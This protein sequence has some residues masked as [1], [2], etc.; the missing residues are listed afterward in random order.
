MVKWISIFLLVVVMGNTSFAQKNAL[1][2]EGASPDLYLLHKVVPKEN[3]YSIGR[4]YNVSPKGLAS[5]N[6]LQF[7]NG[8]SVGETLKIPLSESNFSQST[9]GTGAEGLI[10]V[11]HHV[12][13][14]EGL[15][16][17]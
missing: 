16:R 1:I 2:I 10:P 15:Y 13:P 9:S 17:V 6:N 3:F 4:L 14:K 12:Q 5:Y 8:L 11:Y 7:E